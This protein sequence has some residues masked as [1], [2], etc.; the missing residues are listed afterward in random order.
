MDYPDGAFDA[1]FYHHVIEH[2]PDSQRSI[3]ECACASAGGVICI[4][5][6]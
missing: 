5:A 4:A 1:V 2:V 3:V 6:G